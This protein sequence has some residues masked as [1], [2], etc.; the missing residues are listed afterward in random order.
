MKKEVEKFTDS[1]VMEGMVSIRA[2]L[3]GGHRRIERVLYDE[4][5]EGS[6]AREI[7]FLRHRGEEMGFSVDKATA[8]EIDSVTVGSSHGGIVAL[9]SERTLPVLT[10]DDISD[11]GFWVMLEGIEDPY[12]FGYCLRSLYAAGVDGIIVPPRNWMSA[13]GV[14]CRA[15]AGAGEL[16]DIFVSDAVSAAQMMKAKGYT[17]VAADKSADA[18]SVYDADVRRPMLLLVGGEKRGNTRAALDIADM[19]VALDYGRDFPAALSAA[20]AA[21]V[22]AF[23]LF[24]KGRHEK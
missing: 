6:H 4:S 15:S 9:C 18:V 19:T 8:E 12:N 20:S 10:P 7:A 13:A 2:V 3:S 14:V 1:A 11:G 16:F 5:R 24:R 22:I 17:V 21:S 23:E